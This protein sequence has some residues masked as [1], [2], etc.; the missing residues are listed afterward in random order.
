[1]PDEILF[2]LVPVLLERI[3]ERSAQGRVG[4]L[5]DNIISLAKG[6]LFKVG[7]INISF[8]PSQQL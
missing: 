6:G 5:G 3:E 1:M 2:N 4:E 8:F 7:D